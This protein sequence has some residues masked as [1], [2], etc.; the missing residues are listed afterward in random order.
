MVNQSFA[1]KLLWLTM[2]TTIR[3]PDGCQLPELCQAARLDIEPRIC[4]K[5][6]DIGLLL[7]VAFLITPYLRV[8]TP[9]SRTL[10]SQTGGQTNGDSDVVAKDDITYKMFY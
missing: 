7:L 3:T 5:S 10:M 9:T 6:T 1:K 8:G 2:L 4:W